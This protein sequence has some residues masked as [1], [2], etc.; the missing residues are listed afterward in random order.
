M[1]LIYKFGIIFEIIAAVPDPEN[2]NHT[3]SGEGAVIG[4]ESIFEVKFHSRPEPLS[5]S[6]YIPEISGFINADNETIGRYT[7]ENI[8]EV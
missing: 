1:L 3:F 5:F 4:K 8:T 7:A 6:W 2:F